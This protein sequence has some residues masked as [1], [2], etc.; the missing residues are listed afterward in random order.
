MTSSINPEV[1]S[2]SPNPTIAFVRSLGQREHRA[3]EQAFIVEGVRAVRDA[4]ETGAT[5]HLVLVRADR[6]GEDAAADLALPAGASV[7][8]VA[9]RLFDRLSDVQTPQGVLAVFPL[10][11][12]SP[13]VEGVGAPLVLVLDRLRDP[14]NLGTLLRAAAG[15]GVTGVY[16]TPES[17]DPWNP[18][19]VRAGM[20]AHFRVP[21][22][23][24][25]PPRSSELQYPR[26]AAG[27]GSGR[28]HPDVR[29]DRLDHSRG[30]DRR[31][32]DRGRQPCPDAVVN[33]RGG[34]PAAERCRV[35]QC[36]RCRVGDALRSGPSAPVN[37]RE[38]STLNGDVSAPRAV[39]RRK[40]AYVRGFS[41]TRR[42]IEC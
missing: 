12:W 36:S 6:S 27:S 38:G 3:A 19:V 34:N 31:R 20:G 30:A 17:V 16:L 13:D 25:D 5:P 24:L 40:S 14:G 10:P 32:G 41:W 7:R 28:R 22:F 1:I 33:G 18:K 2:S 29:H 42:T 11:Q 26:P 15:A 39:A 37:C 9:P 4:L 23:T 35:T 21:V 8:Y